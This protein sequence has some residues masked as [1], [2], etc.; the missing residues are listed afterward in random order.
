[1]G[2]SVD[3]PTWNKLPAQFLK[4]PE[5][6]HVGFYKSNSMFQMRLLLS[7][8]LLV[9]VSW[10][11][12]DTVDASGV[13]RQKRQYYGYGYG[14]YGGYY[15][16]GCATYAPCPH[17]NGGG[18]WGGYGGYGYGGYGGGYGGYGGYGYKK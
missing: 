2:A 4:T 16:C 13:I 10:I 3:G 18:G 9:A 11:I 5:N 1:G 15:G 8:F 12:L 14:G 7:L 6:Q 17:G